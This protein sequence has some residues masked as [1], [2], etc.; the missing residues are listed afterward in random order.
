MA[1]CFESLPPYCPSCDV[2]HLDAIA[3]EPSPVP[4]PREPANIIDI[5]RWKVNKFFIHKTCTPSLWVLLQPGYVQVACH[6][7]WSCHDGV[8]T[9]ILP[10]NIKSL[11][12]RSMYVDPDK[13]AALLTEFR[14]A[15][16][17]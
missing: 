10:G 4:E 9:G 11:S 6:E 3:G 5:R 1:T 15:K 16:S 13:A 17:K 12:L 14:A 8:A 2:R 7:C